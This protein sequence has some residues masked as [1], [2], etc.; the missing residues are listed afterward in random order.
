VNRQ[1][2]P[3]VI[4]ALYVL[5]GCGDSK[6]VG[7]AVPVRAI[8]P[9]RGPSTKSEKLSKAVSAERWSEATDLVRLVKPVDQDLF[10]RV[11][12]RG[13]FLAVK[14]WVEAGANLKGVAGDRLQ[15][16]LSVAAMADR[17]DLIDYLV[18]KGAV[19]GQQDSTGLSPLMAAAYL[20]R[21][22]ALTSLCRLGAPLEQKDRDKQTALMFAANAGQLKCV[23]ILL[24]AGANPNA[25]G[26]KNATPAM[27]AAQQGHL[28]CLKAIAGAGGD[29]KAIAD[30]GISAL[31]LA[32]QNNKNETV[33]WLE[34]QLN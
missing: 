25:R 27:F 15:P 13:P 12:A 24:L 14:A 4:A 8:S 21:V 26:E 7:N 5:S 18:H 1:A 28:D 29:L 32:K 20:G 10:L 23:Q 22:Q 9:A 11:V 17:V 34:S 6:Q 19:L 31:F 3:F 2:L 30:E 33:K 16:P